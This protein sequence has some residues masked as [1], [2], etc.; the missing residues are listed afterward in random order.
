M[1]IFD[2]DYM[3]RDYVPK[4][5]RRMTSV[6]DTRGIPYWHIML[7]AGL[8]VAAGLFWIVWQSANTST[9]PPAVD[10]RQPKKEVHRRPAS[11]LPDFNTASRDQLQ[12]MPFMNKAM[13]DQIIQKQPFRDWDQVLDVYGIGPKRLEMLRE[14][15]TLG[16]SS[17]PA[18]AE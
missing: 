16:S 2:R 12:A 10:K 11:S 8:L 3:R 14:H 7:G 17:A 18:R 4:A 1:G 13:A 9:S 6:P 15:F 5:A